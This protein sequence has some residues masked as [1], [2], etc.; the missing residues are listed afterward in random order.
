[1][2]F[3]KAFDNVKHHLLA[4]KLKNSPLS[5]P[6]INWYLSFLEDRKQRVVAV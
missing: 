3:S 6:M 2:D 4:E 5:L 1:M